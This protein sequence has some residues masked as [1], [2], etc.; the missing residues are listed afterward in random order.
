MQF[1]R[2]KHPFRLISRVRSLVLQAFVAIL[3]IVPAWAA[4]STAKLEEQVDSFIAA[5]EKTLEAA[6]KKML[7]AI[8]GVESQVRRS[9]LDPD[10][11]KL[12]V[13]RIRNDYEHCESTKQLPSCDE[14]VGVAIDF[15]RD[16]DKVHMEIE[17]KRKSLLDKSIKTDKVA[18][19]KKLDELEARV[20]GLLGDRVEFQPGDDWKGQSIGPKSGAMILKLHITEVSGSVFRGG[21][22]KTGSNNVTEIMKV[23][24]TRDGNTFALR[25]TQMIKGPN[26]SWQMQGCVLGSRIVATYAGKSSKGKAGEGRI[27][28]T[29]R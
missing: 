9:D 6:H 23:E 16:L 12:T 5:K 11:K 15:V 28:L 21:L 1:A 22:H 18:T 13:D 20:A 3:L 17:K 26:Q 25:T 27:S 4:D 29:K 10:A 8:K 7:K 2:C 24:G 19:A 14:L